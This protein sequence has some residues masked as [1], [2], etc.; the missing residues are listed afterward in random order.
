MKFLLLSLL[1]IAYKFLIAL[2][3]TIQ[4]KPVCVKEW[5]SGSRFDKKT[6]CI[7]HNRLSKYRGKQVR[8]GSVNHLLFSITVYSVGKR[9]MKSILIEDIR[10]SPDSKILFLNGCENVATSACK[11]TGGRGCPES[12]ES[13]YTSCRQAVQRLRLFFRTEA[14]KPV[15][16]TENK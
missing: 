13:L 6:D 15:N 9:N 4:R 1:A 14:E 10:I 7:H 3:W 11:F 12:I 2:L 5:L 16:L 8:E